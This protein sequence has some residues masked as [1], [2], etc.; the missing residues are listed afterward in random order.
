MNLRIPIVVLICGLIPEACV[1]KGLLT[2]GSSVSVGTHS[3]GALRHAARLP[4]RG[5]GYVIPPTWAARKRNY[6]TDE[7]VALLGRTARRVLRRYPRSRLAV[8]DL[9]PRGGGPTH[10]HGSHRSGRDVDLIYY[11]TDLQG[12]PVD[13]TEMIHYDA[14][15]HSVQAHPHPHAT[16]RTHPPR[17]AGAAKRPALTTANTAA[18]KPTRLDLRRNWALVSA[19]VTDPNVP[20]QWIFIGRRLSRLLL[21]YARRAHQPSQLVE[22]VALVMR[23]PGDASPHTDHIHVRVFCDPGDR[24]QGCVDR[25][26]RRFLGK[27]LKYLDAPP[28]GPRI[29]RRIL[30]RLGL[31]SAPYP[32]L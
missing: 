27:T 25:G 22:R 1:G 15:G 24:Y 5:E 2:D 6:G 17:A 4:L 21:R 3:R 7:L 8:A 19:L 14:T 30:D 10:E 18:P 12:H 16:K 32:L 31:R 9:S 26:P 13:P 29:T 23:Q 11:A 28:R 20:V